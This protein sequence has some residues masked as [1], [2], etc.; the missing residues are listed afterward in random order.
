MDTTRTTLG[1]SQLPSSKRPRY[2]APLTTYEIET[3]VGDLI[4]AQ[5]SR[6]RL[7]TVEKVSEP[8]SFLR[9]Q[10]TRN[11]EEVQEGGAKERPQANAGGFRWLADRHLKSPESTGQ[12]E[13]AEKDSDS[14]SDE[15][16]VSSSSGRPRRNNYI[17]PEVSEEEDVEETKE[18]QQREEEIIEENQEEEENPNFMAR[19]M[20]YFFYN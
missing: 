13:K 10:R 3:P 15:Y 6:H 18:E 12:V 16:L 11:D 7:S 5:I 9:T 20:H 2:S 4:K 1:L 8:T 14:N 19:F 17:S